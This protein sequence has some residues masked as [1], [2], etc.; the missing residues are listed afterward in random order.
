MVGSNAA[1]QMGRI[2]FVTVFVIEEHQPT[3]G[4]TV[5]LIEQYGFPIG[6]PTGKEVKVVWAAWDQQFL[7]VDLAHY[8]YL[9]GIGQPAVTGV[10]DLAS[11]R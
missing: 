1:A 2:S 5:G 11:I 9:R 10:D 7:T 4:L 6:R 8:P 3:Q